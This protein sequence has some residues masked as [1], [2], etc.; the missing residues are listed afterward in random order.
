[1]P[2]L[3][4]KPA[5]SLSTHL[6]ELLLH[7]GF[8]GTG[9]GTVLLGS[10]LPRLSL[11][12]RL[13]DKDAGL[14]LMVQFAASALGALFA[15]G[16]L[17]STVAIGYAL[18]GVGG[19]AIFVLQQHSLAA[20]FPFGLGMGMAMTSTSLLIGRRSRP[21]RGAA[22]AILNAAWSA[23]A[24]ACPLVAALLLHSIPAGH[25]FALLGLCVL[26]FAFLPAFVGETN[27]AQPDAETNIPAG[28]QQTSTIIYFA[29]LAFLYVGVESSV[30]NWMSTYAARDAA[31]SYAGSS[32]AIALFW[33]ALLLGRALT[34]ACLWALSELRLYRLAMVAAIAGISLMLTAH[35][36]ATLLTAS[37][38]TGFALGPV[39]PLNASLFLARIGESRNAG[40]MFAMAGVGGAVCSWLTGIVSSRSGSLRIGLTVPEG[41]AILMAAMAS[42]LTRQ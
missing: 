37:I 17:R 19:L 9:M 8:A 14:L 32:G 33:A 31:L 12:W 13:R 40:W 20:F 10:I 18:F 15:R 38:L 16:H 26:P 27:V 29:A 1:M 41:A 22:M 36:Q 3:N 39:F 7:V 11:Q 6:A 24:T 23:G 5:K 25:L 4:R 28:R 34:P 35:H 2:L 21:G 42:R 30:S